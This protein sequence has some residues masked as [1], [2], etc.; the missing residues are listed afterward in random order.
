MFSLALFAGFLV[1]AGASPAPQNLDLAA[2]LA[3]TKATATGPPLSAVTQTAVY[4][5]S[6][7]TAD[8]GVA[9][10]ASASASAATTTPAARLKRDTSTNSTGVSSSHTFC[11]GSYP[12]DMCIGGNYDTASPPNFYP[13]TTILSTKTG[14]TTTSSSTVCPTQPEAGTYCGF[15][16][17]EDNCAPQPDGHGPQV[18]PDTIEAFAAYQS[19]HQSAKNAATPKG[20]VNTFRDLSASSSASSYIG[21]YTLSSYDVTGC[22]QWCDNTTLCTAFNIYVERDPSLNPSA[23]QC[24][25]P[26]SITNYK[27]TLWG[28]S[29]DSTTAT[30]T[31]G[32]RGNF[33]VIITASNGY[34][35]SNNTTPPTCSGW[36]S[37][38]NCNGKA[39]SHSSTSLGSKF[40]SGPYNPQLCA[41]YATAQNAAN[42]K[43]SLWSKLVSYIYDPL[44][45]DFF[46]AYELKEDG[47][48]LGTYCTLFSKQYS[49]SEASYVPG[50]LSGHYYGVGSSWS[51]SS[52]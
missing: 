18:E 13:T 24:L 52:E 50:W 5:P 29:L 37:P 17:P 42:T 45:C 41:T 8:I 31:G 15:I 44:K 33:E 26:P 4:N 28:S 23:S 38:Q 21:L 51:Y 19:F 36:Q 43:S 30:N 7:A 34:D 9:S 14:T 2:V 40:F 47:Q 49:T 22:S 27:C 11:W 35:A 6:S 10:V 48:P 39:H 46:N 1:I 20:Y 25:N 32:W 16:N 3:A 12:Q